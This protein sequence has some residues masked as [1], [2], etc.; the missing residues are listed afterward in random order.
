MKQNEQPQSAA[1]AAFPIVFRDNDASGYK[2]SIASPAPPTSGTT[3][4]PRR[5]TKTNDQAAPGN[6]LELQSTR[7]N[8]SYTSPPDSVLMTATLATAISCCD[9]KSSAYFSEVE[10]V[11]PSLQ[12]E[13]PQQQHV[14]PEKAHQ[15]WLV[16]SNINTHSVLGK[17]RSRP[18]SRDGAKEEASPRPRKYRKAVSKDKEG[19]LLNKFCQNSPPRKRRFALAVVA[20]WKP[21]V[22][23]ATRAD[24]RRR[25]RPTLLSSS[26]WASVWSTLSFCL[27]SLSRPRFIRIKSRTLP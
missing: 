14:V 23:K 1:A 4:W 2:S 24:R 26:T 18:C 12:Q 6:T 21:R 19:P 27:T 3:D 25:T 15:K 17:R 11:V 10:T 22:A 20:L 9:R 13:T 16:A 8:K 5:T 7:P